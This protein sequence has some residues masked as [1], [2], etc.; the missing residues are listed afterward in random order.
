MHAVENE[1][2]DC[3]YLSYMKAAITIHVAPPEV[4]ENSLI[5]AYNTAGYSFGGEGHVDATG[6]HFADGDVNCVK[7]FPVETVA[8]YCPFDLRWQVWIEDADAW[9]DAGIT[10]VNAV[11]VTWKDPNTIVYHT[12]VDLGCTSAAGQTTADN[13]VSAIWGNFAHPAQSIRRMDGTQLNYY[14]GT[15][16]AVNT[17]GLLSDLN[18]SGQCRAWTEFLMDTLGVQGIGSLETKIEEANSPGNH[19][20]IIKKW[21]FV[22]S[23]SS[24]GTTP[25]VFVQDVD[26]FYTDPTPGQGGTNP[27]GYFDRHYMVKYTN[28]QSHVQFYDPSYGKGPYSS[29]SAW[30]KDSLDGFGYISSTG[31]LFIRKQNPDPNTCETIFTP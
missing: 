29:Q 23:G 31:L 10:D 25:Y 24:P 18:G 9:F 11:Y 20:L 14:A 13:I 2:G 19:K 8:R 16:S 7:K 28:G 22:G 26:A 12:C 1:I 5:L 27:P 3:P 6:L 15:S 17:A 21:T 4:F 30:E